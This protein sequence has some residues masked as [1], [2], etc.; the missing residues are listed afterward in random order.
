MKN[1]LGKQ[2]VAKPIDQAFEVYSKRI[3]DEDMLK[4]LAKHNLK[5]AGS[6]PSVMWELFG[7]LLTGRSGSGAVGADLFGW[8]VK[9]AIRGS[10]YEYQYHLNTGEEK[11]EE[12]CEVNHLFCSYTKNYED[13][14]VMAMP[15]S[16]L[17]KDYF[18]AWLPQYR[19]NYSA[20][21]KAERRQ[22]FRKS[23]GHAVVLK[24][25]TKVLEIVGGKLV[26]RND[27][28]IPKMN[29]GL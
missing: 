22:R 12:D 27:K 4:L 18:E 20:Q 19:K 24:R 28:L 10:G 15:G 9:S 1:K 29:R 23:I 8:E 25:G 6:V 17:A 16:A 5:V 2:K 21:N 3:H 13:V 7:S 14:L 26:F 11:L